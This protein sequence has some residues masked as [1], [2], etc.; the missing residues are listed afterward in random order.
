MKENIGPGVNSWCTE[1]T[2][3][4]LKKVSSGMGICDAII[5]IFFCSRLVWA[6]RIPTPAP[7]ASMEHSEGIRGKT[8]TKL[9]KVRT[10]EEALG[11]ER[12]R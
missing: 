8:I 9:G 2:S 4:P 6:E 7:C 12:K 5:N 3:L 11:R 10:K 1:V